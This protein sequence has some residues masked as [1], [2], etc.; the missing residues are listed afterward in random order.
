[1]L[2][3]RSY[4]SNFSL[5]YRSVK[6]RFCL[7]EGDDLLIAQIVDADLRLLRQRVAPGHRQQIAL[8][9]D[10]EEAQ[11]ADVFHRA[12][13]AE[14]DLAAFQAADDVAGIAA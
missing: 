9:G 5:K 11:R 1:M 12:D 8:M 4:S 7:I 10:R 13:E 2:R 6:E 3:V 14:I